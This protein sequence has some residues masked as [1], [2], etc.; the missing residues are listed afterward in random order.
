MQVPFVDL[1]AVHRDS[2]AAVEP[3]VLEILR[4]GKFVLGEWNE[5]LESELASRHGVRHG[6]AVNSGTDAL[7][8]A[9]QAAGIGPGDE[10]ITT[11]FT[12]V[13]S[14]ETIVQIGAKPVFVDIDPETFNLD[15]TQVE[16]KINGNTRAILP[17]HLFGQLCDMVSLEAIAGRYGLMILEDAAQA[18][19]CHQNGRF[20]G[21]W[22]L[23][24]GLSFYV[25]KNL[26]AAGDGGLIL[27]DD[28]EMARKSRSLRI[29]G[30]GRERYYY[31]E[32]GY[33]SRLAE[34]QAA[35]L[36]GRLEHLDHYHQRRRD[37]ASIYLDALQD[38]EGLALPATLPGNHHTYHQF[39][40]RYA[41]RDGLQRFLHDQG[42]GTAIY[43][44]V[45][46]H[47]HAPY[48]LYG[49]GEGSLPQT[50]NVAREVL[51]LPIHPHLSDEQVSYAADQVRTYCRQVASV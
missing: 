19:E 5:R 11:T 50:E 17:V 49:G 14:I 32:V 30:M 10:V 3:A 16:G 20:A 37:L 1:P 42:V 43:Y 39:S 38:V 46:L 27:T 40:V 2:Q 26:G 35:V 21:Q 48:A 6:I 4:T 34:I 25:T 15:V 28:D 13:S 29:H 12:F 47:L 44:P 24:A 33:T 36:C 22:G 18:I 31:D 8:I 41:D 45:P 7:R 9:M 51:C 23:A